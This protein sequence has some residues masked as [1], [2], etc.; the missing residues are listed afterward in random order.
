MDDIKRGVVFGG[1]GARGA[2]E[3]GVWKALHELGYDYSIVVGTSIGAINGAMMAQGHYEQALEFWETIDD[4]KIHTMKTPIDIS[5]IASSI[6]TV[7]ALFGAYTK[8]GG[9]DFTPLSEALDKFIDEDALRASKIDFG[10]VTVQLPEAK[11]VQ[12]FKDEIP[13]GAIK[14]YILASAACFPIMKT[15]DID[16]VRYIDGGFRNNLPMDMAYERGARELVVVDLDSITFNRPKIPKDCKIIHIKHRKYLG[17]MMDFRTDRCRT[18]IQKGYLSTMKAFGKIEGGEY[19]FEL[20]EIRKNYETHK[21]RQVKFEKRIDGKLFGRITRYIKKHND[22]DGK[23]AGTIAGMAECL[24]ECFN[25][26]NSKIYNFADFNRE[27]FKKVNEFKANISVEEFEKYMKNTFKDNDYKKMV[28]DAGVLIDSKT[29]VSFFI[30][31]IKKE[32]KGIAQNAMLWSIFT[33]RPME[34]C[35]AVYY[36]ILEDGQE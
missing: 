14:D 11:A 23:I 28:K 36:M 22:T 19:Y 17:M 25:M 29:V 33:L 6:K 3:M 21:E 7:E 4:S 1:G 35:A 18:N 2:Y 10:V 26:D 5:T 12:K 15:H 32:M 16:G 30:Y 13:Q 31:L 8:S 34:F 24:G 9:L 27:V 20:G